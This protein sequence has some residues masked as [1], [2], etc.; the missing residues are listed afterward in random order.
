MNI[1]R[2]NYEIFF[3]DYAEGNLS[4]N[5]IAELMI[6]LE[7]NAD[8]KEE[9]ESY[10]HI[11]LAP[12]SQESY[13]HKSSLKKQEERSSMPINKDNYEEYL[14]AE[15]EGDLNNTE[16]IVLSQ[17]LKEHPALKQE[18]VAFGKTVLIPDDTVIFEN[19]RSLKRVPFLRS[20][21]RTLLYYS[22]TAAAILLFTIL[23]TRNSGVNEVHLHKNITATNTT[24]DQPLDAV[25]NHDVNE[26][27]SS[28]VTVYDDPSIQ[29]SVPTPS[30][31]K[32]L[33]VQTEPSFNRI[34]DK[35]SFNV[36]PKETEALV[37][38]M[39]NPNKTTNNQTAPSD[40]MA[41]VHSSNTTHDMAINH[42]NAPSHN[43]DSTGKAV[44]LNASEH[45]LAVAANTMSSSHQQ[46]V[47]I[48]EFLIRGFKKKVLRQKAIEH[49][50]TGLSMV[51]LADASIKGSNKLFGTNMNMN[52]KYNEKGELTAFAFTAGR[53]SISRSK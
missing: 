3:L 35:V 43:V 7:A 4:I 33:V 16:Q 48:K 27:R 12:L 1:K 18:Q 20:R 46:P 28:G 31:E 47:S 51:D 52:R 40:S 50:K 15:L 34:V 22:T 32:Q 23:F 24:S 41:A 42:V 30:V 13:E 37:H 39:A 9:F 45:S 14:L 5:Q 6:F 36:A 17:F 29:T 11:T 38:D 8:L 49:Q 10:E 19:K 53:F 26:T 2:S 44:S 21:Y 25:G